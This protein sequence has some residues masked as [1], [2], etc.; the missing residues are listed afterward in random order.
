M[1]NIPTELR[2]LVPLL[3]K[4][5]ISDDVERARLLEKTSKNKKEELM[6]TVN[7]LLPKINTF[8]DSFGDDPLSDEAI[9]LGDLAQLVCELNLEE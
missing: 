1:E 8:L 3:N 2:V 6:N 4:W 9:L 5:C 7:P